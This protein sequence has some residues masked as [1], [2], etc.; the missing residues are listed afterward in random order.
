MARSRLAPRRPS[1]AMIVALLALF[2]A[3]G[4]PAQAAH[5]INGKLLKRGSVSGKAIKDHSVT[6]ADLSKR[7]VRKLQTTPAGSVTE[8]KLANRAVTPGKLAPG[9]VGSAAIA[10]G[11]VASGN[12]ATGA[13]GS[14]QVADGSLTGADIA[15]GGLAA[16]DIGRFWGRFTVPAIPKVVAHDCWSGVPTGR[17][18]ER[19]G[20]DIRGDV[21]LITPTERFPEKQLTFMARMQALDPARPETKSQFVLAA[22][23]PT[24]ADVGPFN[25]ITFNY[26]IID[27]P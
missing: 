2:V 25:D 5:L 17:A 23:N 4:G 27:I 9:A 7:A 18:P 3:L 22:C 20:A 14:P 1:A 24:G 8:S 10:A 6:T 16:S 13:V 12:L 26:V 11:G 15:D 19:A 21:I